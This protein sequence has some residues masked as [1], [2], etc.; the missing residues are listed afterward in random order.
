MAGW[1]PNMFRR[2]SVKKPELSRPGRFSHTRRADAR[3]SCCAC[4]RWRGWV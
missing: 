4:V 1:F 3:R 2:E